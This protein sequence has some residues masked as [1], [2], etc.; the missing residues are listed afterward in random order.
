MKTRILQTAQYTF[1]SIS[2]ACIIYTIAT[3]II[4]ISFGG[5][6]SNM[7]VR[8]VV[9]TFAIGIMFGLCGAIWTVERYATWF[10]ILVS[11]GIGII[12]Y[13]LLA[14]WAGWIPTQYGLIPIASTIVAMI[15]TALIIAAIFGYICR[16]DIDKLNR[17]IQRRRNA[18]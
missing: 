14:L 11:P 18:N 13:L 3:G 12:S 2:V 4:G 16:K 5:P 9:A 10:K 15:C 7:I 17:E 6:N 1:A 8:S